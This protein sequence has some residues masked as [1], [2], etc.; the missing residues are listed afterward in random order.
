MHFWAKRGPENSDLV[1]RVVDKYSSPAGGL[2]TDSEDA[3][4]QR[5][6]DDFHTS[7]PVTPEWNDYM[8]RF[9]DLVQ[10]GFGYKSPSGKLD[11]ATLFGIVFSVDEVEDYEILVD[12]LELVHTG[13]CG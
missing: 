4:D 3:G 2:C 12:D 8:V 9:E 11:P 5:C 1:L 7:V 6:N 10:W 13:H